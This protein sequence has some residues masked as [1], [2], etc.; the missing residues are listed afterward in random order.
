M[1]EQQNP[2]LQIGRTLTERLPT[3]LEQG[4]PAGL[5]RHIGAMTIRVRVPRGASNDHIS[6][7]IAASIVNAL[8]PVES[9]R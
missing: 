4:L 2:S 8:K 5:E 1:R 3:L 7:A 6:E 9:G